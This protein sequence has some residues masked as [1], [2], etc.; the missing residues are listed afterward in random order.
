MSTNVVK[1]KKR[2]REKN[3]RRRI[4]KVHRDREPLR[5]RETA[6]I[7]VKTNGKN[8]RIEHD[9]RD[10]IILKISGRNKTTVH[11]KITL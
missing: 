3:K 5:R 7:S 6:E 4:S 1:E 2:E 9:R 10:Q 11:E 8:S